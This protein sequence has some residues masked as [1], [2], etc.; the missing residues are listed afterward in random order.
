M[1]AHPQKIPVL[2]LRYYVLLQRRAL[3]GA[4]ISNGMLDFEIDDAIRYRKK[5]LIDAA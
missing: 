4:V 5:G 2:P 3:L 1:N